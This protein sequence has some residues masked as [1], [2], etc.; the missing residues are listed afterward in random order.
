MENEIDVY[1]N[2]V[3]GTVLPET[4]FNEGIPRDSRGSTDDWLSVSTEATAVAN[5]WN[6]PMKSF[7]KI[8]AMIPNQA[9]RRCQVMCNLGS[10]VAK[11]NI[12]QPSSGSPER[13]FSS[14]DRTFDETQCNA[15][16]D[17]VEGSMMLQYN[18]ED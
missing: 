16:R 11:L 12:V 17:V 18:K 10:V 1:M 4:T 3:V 9:N 2:E 6:C 13:V 7:Q 14:L 5:W 8:H 15:L